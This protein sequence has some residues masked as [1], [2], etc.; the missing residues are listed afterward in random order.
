MSWSSDFH[1]GESGTLILFTA[2][3]T[4]ST[5]LLQS[6]AK[7]CKHQMLCLMATPGYQFPKVL[8]PKTSYLL[9]HPSRRPRLRWIGAQLGENYE[10][11]NGLDWNQYKIMSTYARRWWNLKF[12][13]SVG[14]VMEVPNVPEILERPNCWSPGHWSATVVCSLGSLSLGL[15]FQCQGN[16]HISCHNIMINDLT[17]ASWLSPFTRVLYLHKC[18]YASNVL[19]YDN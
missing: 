11:T 8:L 4:S 3:I 7:H 16:V 19:T 15:D 17:C 9:N 2:L 18:D 12:F 13:G 10:E 1:T 6:T 5:I 14:F